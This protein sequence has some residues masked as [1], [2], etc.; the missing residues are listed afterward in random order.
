MRITRHR[1]S[2]FNL[3]LKNIESGHPIAFETPFHQAMSTGDI[4]I[5]PDICESYLPKGSDIWGKM[6]IVNLRTGKLSWVGN[7][8]KVRIVECSVS[9]KE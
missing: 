1:E 7:T 4:F 6:P 5:V 3:V 8:R 2:K 9:I